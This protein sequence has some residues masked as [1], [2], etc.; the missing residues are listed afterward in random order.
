M[1]AKLIY[2]LVDEIHRANQIGWNLITFTQGLSSGY[3]KLAVSVVVVPEYLT[4]IG[5]P[6]SQNS[7]GLQNTMALSHMGKQFIMFKMLNKMRAVDIFYEV[8]RDIQ[9]TSR[10]QKNVGAAVHVNVDK[11][12]LVID[13]RSKVEFFLFPK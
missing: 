9:P 10:I 7:T 4:K 11:P 2:R 6:K 8:V 12:G 3:Q 5:H 1:L 13:T